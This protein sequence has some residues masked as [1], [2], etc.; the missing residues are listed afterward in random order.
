MDVFSIGP[1]DGAYNIP[2][3]NGESC[4]MLRL[5]EAFMSSDWFC[6]TLYTEA[7]DDAEIR[8]EWLESEDAQN[9]VNIRQK[10]I[11]CCK[12]EL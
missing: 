3:E 11:P 12:A 6:V 8:L 9:C 2:A 10:L 5:N 1:V 4:F 7:G